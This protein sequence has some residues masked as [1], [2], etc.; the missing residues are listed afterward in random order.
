MEN[1]EIKSLFHFFF[2][3]NEIK[4]Y[5]NSITLADWILKKTDIQIVLGSIKWLFW[6]VSFY[7]CKNSTFPVENK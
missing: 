1:I 6:N 7:E 2:L 3:T 5:R 4:I